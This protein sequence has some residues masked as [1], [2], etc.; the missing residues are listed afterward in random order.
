MET[1]FCTYCRCNKPAA[2]FVDVLDPKTRRKVNSK[3]GDCKVKKFLS[4][5][6][7]D[8]AGRRVREER[9]AE[10]SRKLLDQ[11]RRRSEASKANLE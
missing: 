2:G 1:R 7:R 10:Q 11:I 4:T 9:K 3:C 8:A 5:A 6:E